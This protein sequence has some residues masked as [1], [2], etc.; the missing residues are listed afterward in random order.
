MHKP[1]YLKVI[2]EEKL[3]ENCATVGTYFIE[4]LNAI[5]SPLIGDVRGKVA[6]VIHFF[7]YFYSSRVS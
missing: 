1:F 7:I 6:L 4:Q 3:Q 5:D 2:E